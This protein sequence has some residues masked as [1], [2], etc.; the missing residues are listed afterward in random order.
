MKR[1]IIRKVCVENVR[2]FEETQTEQ[3]FGVKS[4]YLEENLKLLYFTTMKE[5]NKFTK[6]FIIFILF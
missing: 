1:K 2:L 6:L 3:I 4:N 5:C